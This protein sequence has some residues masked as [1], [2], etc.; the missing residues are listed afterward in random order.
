MKPVSHADGLHTRIHVYVPV[1]LLL[2]TGKHTHVPRF[3]FAHYVPWSL[4]TPGKL[5][6]QDL[7]LRSATFSS[8]QVRK[9]MVEDRVLQPQAT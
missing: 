7:H 2:L 3:T 1:S 5:W 6:P 4:D 8:T 9:H